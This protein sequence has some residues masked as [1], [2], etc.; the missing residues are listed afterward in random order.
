MDMYDVIFE[1]QKKKKKKNLGK[2]GINLFYTSS[3]ANCM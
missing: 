2:M 3:T 1:I